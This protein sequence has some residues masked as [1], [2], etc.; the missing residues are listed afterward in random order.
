MR[1]PA[2]PV[3]SLV[4]QLLGFLTGQLN[5][6]SLRVDSSF[7]FSDCLIKLSSLVNKARKSFTFAANTSHFRRWRVREKCE[8]EEKI[9]LETG[10]E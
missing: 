3:V 1:P 4:W 8:R 9:K 5:K 7:G 2:L 10:K 6:K